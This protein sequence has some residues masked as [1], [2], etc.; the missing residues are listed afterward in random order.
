MIDRMSTQSS[1]V[2]NKRLLKIEDKKQEKD[3]RL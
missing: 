2:A 1:V 3:L